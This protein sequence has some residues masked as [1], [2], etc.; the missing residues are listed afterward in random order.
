[1]KFQDDLEDATA[2]SAVMTRALALALPLLLCSLKMRRLRI[3]KIIMKQLED[4][5]GNSLKI[6]L[7]FWMSVKDCHSRPL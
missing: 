4:T 1:M 5:L 3:E 7:G 6:E 2:K